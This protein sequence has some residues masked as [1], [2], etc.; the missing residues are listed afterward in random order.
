ML[1]TGASDMRHGRPQEALA[2]LERARRLYPRDY[3]I[4]SA[5][6][7]SSDMLG[8]K[9]V[10]ADALERMKE[11]CM[12][13]LDR[14]PDN[15]HCRSMLSIALAQSGNVAEGVKQAERSLAENHDDGRVRY[16]T[17]CTFVYAGQPERAMEQ[18]RTLV[19]T[20]PGFP[21][22]WPARDPDLAPL[23]EIPE[24]VELFGRAEAPAS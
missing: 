17:A 14:A 24:F 21:R 18:L 16:N 19:K 5:F 6:S 3:R 11:V 8:R 10:V 4:L 23:R 1:W 12:E 20:H 13:T 22:E 15:T 9:E 2:V 7:D